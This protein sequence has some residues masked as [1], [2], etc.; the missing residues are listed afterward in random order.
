MAFLRAQRHLLL[1]LL[2]RE[3]GRE[4]GKEAWLQLEEKH[5][6]AS[7]IKCAT[8]WFGG[9]NTVTQWMKS[10]LFKA[11]W[12]WA[13][14]AAN[15]WVNDGQT[16]FCACVCVPDQITI[17][18]QPQI[19]FCS[20]CLS[21]FKTTRRLS[22]SREEQLPWK[23]PFSVSAS[24][25]NQISDEDKKRQNKTGPRL[26]LLVFAGDWV[27]KESRCDVQ[28]LFWLFC[29]ILHDGLAHTKSQQFASLSWKNLYDIMT[30]IDW[31][32]KINHANF[33]Q[34]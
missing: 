14:R 15:I 21:N 6:W 17:N 34:Q 24:S 33:S 8:W 25:L 3:K 32:Q 5:T 27:C 4:A 1:F 26:L 10:P 12:L 19:N 23:T 29:T 30:N 11:L 2:K 20:P 13:S 31:Y 28:L 22:E 16:L 18:L 7:E 9:T